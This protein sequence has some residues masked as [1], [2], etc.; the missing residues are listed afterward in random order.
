M[1]TYDLITLHGELQVNRISE[2]CD[3]A[4][5]IE[6]DSLCNAYINL[7]DHSPRRSLNHKPYLVK[8]HFGF[9]SGD[10]KSNRR[11]EHLGLALFNQSTPCNLPDGRDL[12]I[13]DYQTPLKSKRSD[14]GIGEVDLFGVIDSSIPA[15]IELIIEGLNG[16][17]ADTPL[18]ALLEGLAY[19][20]IVEANIADEARA[21]FNLHVTPKRPDLFVMAPQKYWHSYLSKPSAG[22]WLPVLE[23]MIA[24][25]RLKLD[26]NIHLNSLMNVDFEMGSFKKRPLLK[27]RC[28][29]NTVG[30]EKG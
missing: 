9:P 10:E 12:N 2:F 16:R 8:E 22:D 15:V 24:E 29:L 5:E 4:R 19:C 11:E 21:K 20:A 25:L 13:I 6:I 23:T 7:V 17:K 28:H 14:K 1:T 26:I 30:Q 27:N 18:R 3:V